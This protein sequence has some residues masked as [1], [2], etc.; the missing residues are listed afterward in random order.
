MAPTTEVLIETIERIVQLSQESNQ[1]WSVVKG[2]SCSQLIVTKIWCQKENMLVDNEKHQNLTTLS[3]FLLGSF[4]AFIPSTDISFITRGLFEQLI[5]SAQ[6]RGG[7]L[8]LITM[9][10]FLHK[11]NV[12]INS[13]RFLL[14]V[15]R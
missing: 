11:R 10:T 13:K 12:F 15:F 5:S 2:V 9:R 6:P 1:Y 8:T 4:N 3:C 7:K 14:S